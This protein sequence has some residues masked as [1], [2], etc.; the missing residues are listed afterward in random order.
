MVLLLPTSAN[1][2]IQLGVIA[3]IC[4]AMIIALIVLLMLAILPDENGEE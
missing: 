3:F 1:E 4:V 2:E